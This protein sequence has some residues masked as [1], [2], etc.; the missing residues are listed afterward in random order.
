MELTFRRHEGVLLVCQNNESA[1]LTMFGMNPLLQEMTGYVEDEV[2]GM[3]LLELLA[4]KVAQTVQEFVEYEH[5]MND[6]FEVMRKLREVQFRHKNGHI[7]ATPNFRICRIEARDRHHWFRLIVQEDEQKREVEAFKQAL[8]TN[9]K[10]HEVLDAESGLPDRASIEKDLEM[11][12]Y[13]ADTKSLSACFAYVRLDDYQAILARYGKHTALLALRE[14]ANN[15]R[16]NLRN[17][18]ALGRVADDALGVILTDIA[19][20]STRVVMNRLRWHVSA[21]DVTLE[22]TKSQKLTA[23]FAL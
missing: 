9:F 13:Y 19:T 15:L 14:M 11:A 10:G 21:H 1:S 17:D 4:P 22:G 23:S 6:L 12:Q 20:E 8:S 2:K 7:V 18:D 3:S 5:D 16:H